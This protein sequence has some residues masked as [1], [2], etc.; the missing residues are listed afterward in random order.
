MPF[1][2][3]TLDPGPVATVIALVLLAYHVFAPPLW[4]SRN[5]RRSRRLAQGDRTPFVDDL[6]HGS[7]FVLLEVLLVMGFV[8]TATVVTP[9][10]VGMGAPT[11][12]EASPLLLVLAGTALVIGYPA[13]LLMIVLSARTALAHLREGRMPPGMDRAG[14]VHLPAA[15]GELRLTSLGYALNVLCHVLSVYVVLFPVL[16]GFLDSPLLVVIM[17]GLLTGW[18]YLGQGG[19]TIATMTLSATVALA[20]YTWLVPGSLLVPTLLWAGYGVAVHIG[21]R[22]FL[23]VPI[24]DQARPLHPVEVTLLDAEGRPIEGR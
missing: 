12:A 19:N 18:Q 9:A 23:G 21:M 1:Q 7:W 6:R 17:L 4:R 16:S 14:L 8:G 3:P 10:D 15:R 11:L 20:V 24:P 5:A 2:P 13:Y 22:G